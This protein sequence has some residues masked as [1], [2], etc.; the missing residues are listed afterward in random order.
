M[1]EVPPRSFRLAYPRLALAQMKR[2]RALECRLA[3]ELA[4]TA[5]QARR[6]RRKAFELEAAARELE[7]RARNRF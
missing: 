7:W 3:A 5:Q 1:A 6:L 2:H 4:P